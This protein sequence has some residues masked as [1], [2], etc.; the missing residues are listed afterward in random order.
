[1]ASTLKSQFEGT[2]TYERF[3]SMVNSCAKRLRLPSLAFLIPPKLRTKGRFLSINKLGKWGHKIIEVMAVSGRVKK[4]S[5]IDRFRK[6]SPGFSLLKPFIIRF[7]NNASVV[8]QI[9]EIL[10]NKGLDQRSYQQCHQLSETLPNSK[11]KKRIQLWLQQHI[12]IQEQI[13]SLPLLVSSDI[14][15]SLFGS[16]KHIIE[17]S[18]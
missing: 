2:S 13:T 18:L 10:K 14:I 12:K 11:V 7:A 8:S 4:D 3:I 9:M 1:M 16:F 5:L 17:R 6:A 15:E